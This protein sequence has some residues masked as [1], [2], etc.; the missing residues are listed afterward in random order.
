MSESNRI[1]ENSI[2]SL[3]INLEEERMKHNEAT[4]E[5]REILRLKGY[6]IEQ[7]EQGY[8]RWTNGHQHKDDYGSMEIAIIDCIRVNL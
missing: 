4:K 2:S 7:D 8:Y 6:L 3:R 5:L 1:L